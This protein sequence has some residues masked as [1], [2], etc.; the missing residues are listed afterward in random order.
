MP[1]TSKNPFDFANLD[2]DNAKERHAVYDA[3]IAKGSARTADQLRK[4]VDLGI[5]D[6]HGN[7]ICAG[8]PADMLD[9]TSSVEQ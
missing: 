4:F 5:I 2:L 6:E 3:I 8:T 1:V 9:P 7:A